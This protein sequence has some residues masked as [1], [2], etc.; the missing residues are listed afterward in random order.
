MSYAHHGQHAS[1][2]RE[3]VAGQR[4]ATMAEYSE[5]TR[6]LFRVGYRPLVVDTFE[7]C[8]CLMAD[9]SCGASDV[10]GLKRGHW[11]LPRRAKFLQ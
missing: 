11:G 7:E 8:E 2:D 5:L 1:A 6:E 3:W 9:S 4:P 10:R